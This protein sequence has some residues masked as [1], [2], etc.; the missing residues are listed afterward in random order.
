[1]LSSACAGVC[2][3]S[4]GHV[5]AQY[6]ASFALLCGRPALS[7]NFASHAALCRKP[8][9]K[10]WRAFCDIRTTVPQLAAVLSFVLRVAATCN[11]PLQL[12]TARAACAVLP[13]L[14]IV[15]SMPLQE[16]TS[17]ELE[18]IERLS[19]HIDCNDDGWNALHYAAA[20]HKVKLVQQ[21]LDIGA[22]P[23]EEEGTFGL[24]PLHLAC[25]GRV[26][27]VEDYED[28]R[29][30]CDNIYNLQ[31]RHVICIVI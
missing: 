27:D 17:E 6:A 18:C 11:L 16:A 30:S 7:L 10:S 2:L 25:M 12:A 31:V 14:C 5:G 15:L 21:L 1:V 8:R 23:W 24:R 19:L 28:L 4:Q 29:D 26:Q 3:Q 20:T 22:S 9:L 13:S